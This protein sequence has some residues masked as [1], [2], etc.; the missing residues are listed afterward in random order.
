MNNEN[1]QPDFGTPGPD[2]LASRNRE[3]NCDEQGTLWTEQGKESRR[4]SAP[5]S[6][7]PRGQ[8]RRPTGPSLWG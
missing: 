1:R 2:F 5:R 4:R 8:R 6:G 7:K 3:R